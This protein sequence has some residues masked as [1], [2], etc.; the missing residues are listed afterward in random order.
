MKL[1][2][3]VLALMATGTPTWTQDRSLPQSPAAVVRIDDAIV[4]E[5]DDGT[6]WA[7]FTVRVVGEMHAPF[8]VHWAARDLTAHTGSDYRAMS[9][10][11]HFETPEPQEVA[12]PVYGDTDATEGTEVFYVELSDPV[13]AEIEDGLAHGVIKDDDYMSDSAKCDTAPDG[14]SDLL[15]RHEDTTVPPDT[16]GHNPLHDIWPVTGTVTSPARASSVHY[17]ETAGPGWRLLA[18]D[19]FDERPSC[20][21]FWERVTAAGTT[22]LAVTYTMPPAPMSAPVPEDVLP[23]AHPGPGWRLVGSAQFAGDFRA[24]FLWWHSGT[25]ALVLWVWQHGRHLVAVPL[26]T[27]TGD[28]DSEAVGV[29]D[30]Y[31]DQAGIVWRSPAT[32]AVRYWRMAGTV[33]LEQVDILP[34]SNVAV[35]LDWRL[36]AVGD[37]NGDGNDDLVWQHTDARIAFWF[38][39]SGVVLGQS[40]MSPEVLKMEH[41]TDGLVVGPR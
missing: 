1:A 32:G 5:G 3:W 37:F 6:S 35:G 29:A 8:T 9:G 27:W 23:T 18:A 28:T 31:G 7:R 39:R 41:H 10:D 20:D 22:E 13:Y 38:V 30:L 25:G 36:A 15:A 19:R 21:L 11:L 14:R 2:T 33:V 40:L 24:D 4:R 17:P 34:V 26:E 16:D 12:V